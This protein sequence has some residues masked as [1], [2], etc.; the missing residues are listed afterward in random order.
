MEETIIAQRRQKVEALREQGDHPHANDFRVT[1]T[2]A[3]L[4][5]LYSDAERWTLEALDE[6]AVKVSLA[7]RVRAVRRFGGMVFLGITDG[8]DVCRPGDD[9]PIGRRDFQAALFKKVLRDAHPQSWQ[10]LDLLDIGDIVGVTGQV[11]RSKRG[12]LSVNVAEMRILTKTLRPLPDKWH[13]LTDVSARYR[14]RYVDLMM[15]DEVRR[16]FRT[17]SRVVSQIRRFFEAR[18]Y[19]EVETP[20]LQSIYGG[21]AARPFNTHHNQ[22]DMPLFLRIA[23]EL[24]LKRL[25]VGG[26]HRVFEINRNFRN[27]GSDSEHAPEFA[28]V[29]AYEAYGDYDTMATLTRDLVQRAAR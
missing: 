16:A 22:L 7:G 6:A 2:A 4:H 29:E 20:M 8:S 15:N 10:R 9:T 25:V 3:E 17:R 18:G 14:Q 28:M 23:P 1:H 11:M 26:F 27:E 13:G 5:D 21:A 12:E 19:L 24:A